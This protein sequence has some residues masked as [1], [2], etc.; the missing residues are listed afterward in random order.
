MSSFAA[1]KS[2]SPRSSSS[3]ATSVSS[4][5]RS[6]NGN[7]F[8]KDV[9]LWRKKKISLSILAVSTFTWVMLEVYRFN[10]IPV[11]CWVAMFII[12]SMFLWGNLTRLFNREKPAMDVWEI[13]EQFTMETQDAFRGKLEE[14]I[15]WMFRVGAEE[16]WFIFIEIVV[17]LWLLSMAAGSCSFFL[18]HTSV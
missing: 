18:S 12:T 14:G 16:R 3:K 17:G 11:V 4:P 8:L 7:D 2:S 15:R 6:S 9:Y 10:F 1:V 5:S 13:S